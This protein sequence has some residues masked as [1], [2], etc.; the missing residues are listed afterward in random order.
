M[1]LGAFIDGI[2]LHQVLQWHHLLSDTTGRPTSTVEGLAT[3]TLADGLFHLGAWLFVI[4]GMALAV[5]DWQRRKLR[6][7]GWATPGCSCWVG[8]SS[9]SSRA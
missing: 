2:V 8:A 3:N 6:L 9:T 7:R 1:G 4:V 5:R